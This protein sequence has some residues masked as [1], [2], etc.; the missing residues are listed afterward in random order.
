MSH[1]ISV[2]LDETAS[3]IRENLDLALPHLTAQVHVN[4]QAALKSVIAQWSY[5]DLILRNLDPKYN[6]EVDRFEALRR[7]ARGL[8]TQFWYTYRLVTIELSNGK[9][10]QAQVVEPVHKPTIKHVNGKRG[11]YKPRHYLSDA[12]KR[13]ILD[14]FSKLNRRATAED[15]EY[16]QQTF[17]CS[18]S[19][20][21][22]VR[23]ECTPE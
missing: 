7:E 9:V 14:Y 22:H 1:V 15:Y 4:P 19:A 8:I 17:N 10:V 18:R 16:I 6:L 20:V 5:A 23:Y 21:N 13:E 2:D 12:Q 11:A 3:L